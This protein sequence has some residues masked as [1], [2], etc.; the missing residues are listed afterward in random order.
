[1]KTEITDKQAWF[2][3]IREFCDFN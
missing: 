2:W 1:M 3:R